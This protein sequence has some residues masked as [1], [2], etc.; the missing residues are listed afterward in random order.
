[1]YNTSSL[2]SILDL[3]VAA[4]ASES[5]GEDVVNISKSTTSTLHVLKN[6]L[7]RVV[8]ILI[9]TIWVIGERMKNKGNY[10]RI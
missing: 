2:L 7:T 8:S 4:V 9:I 3:V 1:M 6:T 10:P 5:I